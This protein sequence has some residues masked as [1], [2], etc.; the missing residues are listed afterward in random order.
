MDNETTTLP[1]SSKKIVP[2]NNLSKTG[3]R[4]NAAKAIENAAKMTIN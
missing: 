1:G 4:V 2:F 3:G